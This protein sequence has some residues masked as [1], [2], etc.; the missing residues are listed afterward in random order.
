MFRTDDPIADYNRWDAEQQRLLNR[1]PKCSCCGEPIQQVDAVNVHNCWYCDEC[2][3]QLR[4]RIGD[5]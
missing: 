2:L 3:D 5:D 1:L 4:E